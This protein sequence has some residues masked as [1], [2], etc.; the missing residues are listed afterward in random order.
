MVAELHDF[1]RAKTFSSPTEDVFI[2]TV[3]RRHAIDILQTYFS[4]G[5]D[6]STLM[7]WVDS[8]KSDE[9]FV[10]VLQEAAY[11]NA[12][13]IALTTL[14]NVRYPS[15][16]Q[17]IG[18]DCMDLY[19]S[20][21]SVRD[22]AFKK[23]GCAVYFY[24]SLSRIRDFAH[25]SALSAVKAHLSQQYGIDPK[26]IITEG[27]ISILCE[28]PALYSKMRQDE[29]QIRDYVYREILRYDYYHVLTKKD[30]IVHFIS[31]QDLTPLERNDYI[32]EVYFSS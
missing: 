28:N 1:V 20:L 9:A 24:D 26:W 4:T 7:M 21:F 5:K 31:M 25:G 12:F 13:G 16:I 6:Q 29:P 17:T 23:Y 15:F 10:E 11:S 32:Y 19:A 22:I 30:V 8:S 3:K 14:P 2:E 18:L 27:G